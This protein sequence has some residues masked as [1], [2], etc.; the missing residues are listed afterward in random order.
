M[1]KPF[2]KDSLRQ[3]AQAIKEKIQSG[4]IPQETLDTIRAARHAQSHEVSHA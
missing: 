3:A 2:T 4:E 1:I